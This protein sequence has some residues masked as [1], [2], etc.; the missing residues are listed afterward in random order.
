[1]SVKRFSLT[2]LSL[3]CLTISSPAYSNLSKKEPL[4][5]STVE[6]TKLLN[7]E[8]SLKNSIT[9]DTKNSLTEKNTA[10]KLNYEI[11]TLP[12]QATLATQS[13]KI[14]YEDSNI[15]AHSKTKDSSNTQA[16]SNRQDNLNRQGSSNTQAVLDIQ[17]NLNTQAVSNRQ[18][19]LNRQGSSNIQAVLDIQ[20]N[21]KTKDSSN[22]QTNSKTKD[23]SNRQDSSNTQAVLDIQV[24]SKTKDS[25]NTQAI[26]NRQGSSNRQKNSDIQIIS[27][28][29]ENKQ[30]AITIQKNSVNDKNKA[31]KVKATQDS[32]SENFAPENQ[33][34]PDILDFLSDDVSWVFQKKQTKHK[35]ALVPIYSYDKTESSR[36]GFR[37]FS[38]NPGIEGY[39]LAVSGAKYWPKNYYS[40]ITSY[41]S[42]RKSTFRSEFY[43]IYDDHYENYYGDLKNFEG[44]K[45]PLNELTKLEAHRLIIDHNLFYQEKSSEIYFGGGIRAFFRQERKNL[46]E[47]KSY[48]QSEYF[49]FLRAFAGMDTRDNWKYPKQGVFHQASLGCKASLVYSSA[50]CQTQADARF[51]N[52][53]FKQI[54][55]PDF[56]K[57][58]VF[59][60]RAFY[61]SSL[62]SP[63]SYSTKYS[64]G[65]EGFFQ[66][67]QGLRGFKN[68]RFLGDKMYLAQSEWRLPVWKEYLIA[69]VFFELGE[70][71]QFKESFTGFVSNY[72]G[73][74]RIGWPEDSG[75]KIRLDYSIG[76]DR[77]NVQNND[78]IVSFLQAF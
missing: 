56:I 1:M 57:H 75:M 37:F 9:T 39:F 6:K 7:K 12:L 33:T 74:L 41:K 48:F 4:K 32:I 2:F 46:Q 16:V 38:F 15:Q 62:I 30:N 54:D 47:N 25:S 13:N 20:V 28:P 49:L 36:F 52:S 55:A 3:F 58:S 66:Q 72:G 59:S 19:N 5:T 51:Y 40:S 34:S 44:M 11:L 35:I 14:D 43:L 77:Q 31:E 61:G 69:A 70:A 45:A 21:S 65:G 42:S 18:D 22:T 29:G 23:N 53:L 27:T 26:S 63:A 64:L 68:R 73:G 60:L 17:D 67:L 71:A 8:S 10:Y 50:Y 76:K 24:N 78:F